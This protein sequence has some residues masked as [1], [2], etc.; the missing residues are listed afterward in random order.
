M[1]KNNEVWREI[2]A[3]VKAERGAKCER[4][5]SRENIDLHH[6]KPRSYGGKDV[7]ENAQLLCEPCHVLTPSYGDRS[8][9][10]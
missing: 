2:K 9:L 8:R 6:I 5:G 4:C 3:S 1:L 7:K 10:Q